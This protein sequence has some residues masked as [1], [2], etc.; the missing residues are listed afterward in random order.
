MNPQAAKDAE[1]NEGDYVYVDANQADR[2]FVGA[3]DDDPRSRAF[4]CMVRVKF[5]PSL[6]Y[7]MT[8]MKHTG[9]IA[10]ERTVKAHESSPTGQ[11]QAIDTGY[12]ASYRFGSHQSITRSWLPPMHQTD[13][14]FHKKTGDMG[15]VF[16]FAVDNHGVNTVP[17]ET[18]IRIVKAEPGGLNGVG[19]WAPATTGNSPGT[20]SPDMKRYLEG[21][22]TKVG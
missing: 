14:L 20:E 16:G 19:I 7:S 1:L 13:S 9:W 8:I 15:F 21:S 18:L 22:L 10:T 3:R 2:P 17:K 6:P 4:R 5:N 12:Q 11:A